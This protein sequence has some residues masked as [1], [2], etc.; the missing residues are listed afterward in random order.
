[1]ILYVNWRSEAASE[2]SE[3]FLNEISYQNWENISFSTQIN[4]FSFC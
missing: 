1:M 2:M 3:K 4:A